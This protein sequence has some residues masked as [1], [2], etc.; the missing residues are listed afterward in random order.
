MVEIKTR[1]DVLAFATKVQRFMDEHG[2]GIILACCHLNT[3]PNDTRYCSGHGVYG[4]GMKFED[5]PF[6]SYCRELY[7]DRSDKG[8]H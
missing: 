4:D 1:Q 2:V 7:N 6:K 3:Y 8:G 5:C